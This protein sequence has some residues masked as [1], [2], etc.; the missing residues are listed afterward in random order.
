MNTLALFLNRIASWKSLVVVVILYVSFP[1]YFL[2]NA[3]ETINQKA[4][5]IIGPIDLTLG[6]NPER[7]LQM[8]SAYGPDA[9]DYYANVEMT[10]DVV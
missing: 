8:V 4:G 9:R 10:V 6:Y 2:K 1:A 5:K 3:E 7:T